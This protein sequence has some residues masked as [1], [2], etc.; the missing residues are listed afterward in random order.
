M[1]MVA[2]INEVCQRMEKEISKLA[3]DKK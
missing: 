3:D 2:D 1:K